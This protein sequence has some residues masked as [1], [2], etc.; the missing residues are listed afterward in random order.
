MRVTKNLSGFLN[1]I[2]LFKPSKL[3]LMWNPTKNPWHMVA[4]SVLSH[5]SVFSAYKF[6]APGKPLLFL[7]AFSSM[8]VFYLLH[9][10][11]HAFITRLIT[12]NYNYLFTYPSIAKSQWSLLNL[13]LTLF[14]LLNSPYQLI[15][16]SQ[17]GDY[18]SSLLIFCSN[19]AP[20][21][22]CSQLSF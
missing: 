9:Y 5:Y 3:I 16:I 1:L 20:P 2:S 15:I 8:K 19:L 21:P 7:N 4:R 22:N 10:Y 13:S 11:I 12:L 17:P 6:L 18:R 14:L